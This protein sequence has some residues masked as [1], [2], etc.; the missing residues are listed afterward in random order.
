MRKAIKEAR[1]IRIERLKSVSYATQIRPKLW[2]AQ[3]RYIAKNVKNVHKRR[4]KNPRKTNFLAVSFQY[5][6]PMISV[7]ININGRVKTAN[8]RCVQNKNGNVLSP[9]RLLANM[10]LIY[11]VSATRILVSNIVV[12]LVIFLMRA[13][14]QPS[15]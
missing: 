14:R 1:T 3:G 9:R 15:K 12:I 5:I 11:I 2:L 6:F 13:V 8:E 10:A 4:A 7:V